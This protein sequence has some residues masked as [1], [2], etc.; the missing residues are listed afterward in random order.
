MKDMTDRLDRDEELAAAY[1]KA[2]EDYLARRSQLGE[3]PMLDG[4]SAGGMPTRVKCLHVVAGH[5]LAAGTGVNPF[6][7]E[8]LARIAD[9]GLCG[10]CVRAREVSSGKLTPA[11]RVPAEDVD[12]A[13]G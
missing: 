12:G 5:A 8:V 13:Q 7:D 4:I 10:D 2:H 3:A 9:D 1:Q 11:V 6:G